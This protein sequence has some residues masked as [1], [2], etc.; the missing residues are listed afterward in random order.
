M[1]NQFDSI[2]ADR[3]I[4]LQSLYQLHNCLSDRK[5]LSWDFFLNRFDSLFIEAQIKLGKYE[6]LKVIRGEFNWYPLEYIALSKILKINAYKI[7]TRILYSKEKLFHKI[8]IDRK[9]QK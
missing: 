4:I 5:I 3:P 2:I 8:N 1:E 7:T 6:D 9:H